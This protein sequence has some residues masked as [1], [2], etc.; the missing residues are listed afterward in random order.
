ME[1]QGGP[2]EKERGAF[3]TAK[4]KDFDAE[5]QARILA[6]KGRRTRSNC[7]PGA[8][9]SGEKIYERPRVSGRGT[10]RKPENLNRE[11]SL[12]KT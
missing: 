3:P 7:P 11:I 8:S 1:Y 9:K 10:R 2:K 6:N 12:K 5:K 4:F